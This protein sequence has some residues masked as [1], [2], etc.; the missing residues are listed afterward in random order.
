MTT[1][2]TLND[3]A[4]RIE[5]IN[6]GNWSEDER[7]CNL[8]DLAEELRKQAN[9]P[10]CI[11]CGATADLIK[12]PKHVGGR[13]DVSITECRD[14]VECAHRWNLQNRRQLGETSFALF[15]LA[16]VEQILARRKD[17]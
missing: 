14:Y 1:K 8:G 13:G 9:M 15:E 6:T 12:K 7:N 5:D 16:Y 2:L 3:I 17:K 11:N 10:V 4:D